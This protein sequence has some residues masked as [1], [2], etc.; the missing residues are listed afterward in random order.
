MRRWLL[1]GIPLYAL[2]AVILGL[3]FGVL[4]LGAAKKF[5]TMETGALGAMLLIAI[6]SVTILLY[7]FHS[8]N[9]EMRLGISAIEDPGSPVQLRS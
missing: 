6:A 5:S 9:R 7:G 4:A 8:T 2:E 3:F 1:F